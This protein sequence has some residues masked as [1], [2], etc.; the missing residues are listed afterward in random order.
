MDRCYGLLRLR[1]VG[2]AMETAVFS[3]AGQK[4]DTPA[5]GTL[6]WEEAEKT[7]QPRLEKTMA[8]NSK[9]VR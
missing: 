7:V 2:R 8:G 9:N 5:V 6:P 1:S 4:A 3:P